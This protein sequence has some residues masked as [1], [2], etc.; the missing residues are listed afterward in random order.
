MITNEATITCETFPLVMVSKYTDKWRSLLDAEGIE[1]RGRPLELNY[2][3]YKAIYKDGRLIFIAARDA[4]TG[5]PIGYSSHYLYDDLH[6]NERVGCDDLWYVAKTWR[7]QG[8]G[9]ALKLAGHE[10]ML[11]RG[12][13]RIYD[14]VRHE[15]NVNG[16]MQELGFEPWGVRWVKIFP[17]GSG[18]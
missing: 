14:T 12:A 9:T 13:K 2:E 7:R 4:A 11:A 5:E 15:A 10:I 1:I 16:M 8:I 3:R 6:W 18:S 17:D